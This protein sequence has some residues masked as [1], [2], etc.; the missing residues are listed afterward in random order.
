MSL[1]DVSKNIKK[2]KEYPFLEKKLNEIREEIDKKQK[3][4]LFLKNI[5]DF[6]FSNKELKNFLKVENIGP[7]TLF[8]TH[9]KKGRYDQLDNYL[10]DLHKQ[11]KKFKVKTT[12]EYVLLYLEPERYGPGGV[13]MELGL[14]CRQKSNLKL[15]QNYYFRTLSRQ[16]AAMYEYKGP[17][18]YL[19]FV[20][21]RLFYDDYF[22]RHK[23][24]NLPF[25]WFVK[26][27]ENTKS[28]YDFLT[29][30]VYPIE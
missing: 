14:I 27:P 29:K 11:A 22:K 12:D 9:L 8:A 17:H 4:Y 10:R 5:K 26:N 18:A 30:T 28:P 6:L 19:T 15:P 2:Y 1:K 24:S 23:F 3:E 21:K 13:D 25:D 7:L 20:H 16:K